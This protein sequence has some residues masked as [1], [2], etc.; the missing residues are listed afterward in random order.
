VLLEQLAEHE[1]ADI[2]HASVTL[3]KARQSVPVAFGRRSTSR[4]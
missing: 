1:R 4:G 3:R 2:E